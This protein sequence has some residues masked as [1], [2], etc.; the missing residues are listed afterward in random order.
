MNHEVF[1]NVLNLAA[2]HQGGN[3]STHKYCRSN[4]TTISNRYF[5]GDVYLVYKI[6]HGEEGNSILS[7]IMLKVVYAGFFPV[8]W[9]VEDISH[10][11]HI[12]A[13]CNLLL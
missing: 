12:I 2:L 7:F 9:S 3:L 8:S 5:S 11:L 1:N 6:W 13:M 10:V 4:R